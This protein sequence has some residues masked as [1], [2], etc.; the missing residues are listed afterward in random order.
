V[1]MP[2]EAQEAVFE[3]AELVRDVVV[4]IEPE[5][6]FAVPALERVFVLRLLSEHNISSRCQ[7]TQQL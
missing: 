4:E 6:S 5:G 1:Y 3:E 2:V 7:T